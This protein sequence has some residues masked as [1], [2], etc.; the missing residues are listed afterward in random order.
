MKARIPKNIPRR[1]SA[2][3]DTP[4][5]WGTKDEKPVLNVNELE[6]HM[7]ENMCDFDVV[8]NNEEEVEQFFKF[9]EQYRNNL[10][11]KHK[12]VKKV[13]KEMAEQ[14]QLL[15][16]AAQNLLESTNNDAHNWADIE[17]IM[18]LLED[19]EEI[20]NSAKHYA[21]LINLSNEFITKQ[22]HVELK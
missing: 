3:N 21:R 12:E 18:S 20:K 4:I 7:N 2:Y 13:C 1:R 9:A 17:N 15:N 8:M 5:P 6:S 14:I 19:Y 16:E 10:E 11:S 22:G